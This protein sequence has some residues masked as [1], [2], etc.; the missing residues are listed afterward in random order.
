M[1]KILYLPDAC[2]Y[3][4]GRWNEGT[5]QMNRY[6][7]VGAML[8]EVECTSDDMALRCAQFITGN[9]IISVVRYNGKYWQKISV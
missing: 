7:F 9:A 1:N 3:W 8:H 5:K 6:R 2:A 4:Y